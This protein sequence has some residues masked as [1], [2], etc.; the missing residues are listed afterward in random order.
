MLRKMT[1]LIFALL[2][3]LSLFSGC[4]KSE[5]AAEAVMPTVFVHGYSGWGSYDARYASMP[6]F[7]MTKMNV[8]HHL[9]TA[10]YAVYMASV[11]PYSSAWDRA[12]ELYAQ[13]TGTR[14]DYGAAH[15][16][17][18]GHERYGTDFTGKA[19][20]PD[21]T[22]DAEH[23]INLVGHSFGGVTIRLLLDLLVDGAPEEVAVTGGDTSPLFTGGHKGYVH[24][25]AILSAPSNGTTA[26][27]VD[28]G[29]DAFSS[30]TPGY[31]PHLQQFGVVSS[32]TMNE[33]EASAQM[34]AVG[35]YA[36]NDSALNDMTVD[37]AC[38]INAGIEMQPDVYYYCYYGVTTVAQNGVQEPGENTLGSLLTLTRAMGSYSGVTPGSY[39]VGCGQ[40][41]QTVTVPRQTLGSEWQANDGMVNAP[42]AYC[43]YHLDASGNRVY[44]AHTD[45]TEQT[46]PQPGQWNVYPALPY[47]HLAIVGGTVRFDTKELYAFYD[48]LMERLMKS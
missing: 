36:H 4:S 10:G 8:E 2:L 44:D 3:T 41:V 37:R 19:L 21:F 39:T 14:T 40:S 47:D 33:A 26:V 34:E 46:A 23:P 48:T 18:C 35:F 31:D 16:A 45:A 9:N 29:G 24:A 22:W 13:L 6:Y 27:Y 28:G 15:S 43:P 12:C 17:A 32:S 20:I 7:G 5:P 30:D 42:S 25:L 1:C 38:A 11:G